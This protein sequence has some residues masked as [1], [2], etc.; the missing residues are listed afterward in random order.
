[1]IA[2]YTTDTGRVTRLA[3]DANQD[4]QDAADL[5]IENGS[6]PEPPDLLGV[7]STSLFVV[8]DTLE[9][10]PPGRR[11]AEQAGD[12]DALKDWMKGRV[13]CILAKKE[14]Q[15]VTLSGVTYPAGLPS[16][17][18]IAGAIQQ[19]EAVEADGETFT[20]DARDV[21]GTFHELSLSELKDLRSAYAAQVSSTRDAAQSHKADIDGASTINGLNTIDVTTGW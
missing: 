19:G 8:G 20:F 6:V 7:E 2:V 12:V 9:H 15:P 18:R 13:D 3:H 10:H 21:G 14:V 5:T 16:Q 1:M 11:E 17:S 4:Q